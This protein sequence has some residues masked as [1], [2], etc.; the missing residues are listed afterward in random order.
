MRSTC[1]IRAGRFTLLLLSLLQVV[2]HAEAQD[3]RERYLTLLRLVVYGGASRD[4][5]KPP[6]IS[7]NHALVGF[8]NGGQLEMLL[9]LM[10]EVLRNGV[11]G[12]FM[13]AGTYRG[14]VAIFMAGFIAVSDPTRKVWALDSFRGMPGADY[15]GAKLSDQEHRDFEPGKLATPGGVRHAQ[16][17]FARL[18]LDHLANIVPGTLPSRK[19]VPYASP[20]PM[21]MSMSMSH[22]H[23]HVHV[24]VPCPCPCPCP[25]IHVCHVHARLPPGLRV[26]GWFNETMPM[27]PVKRLAILRVD[28]DIYSSILETLEHMYPKLS[29]GGY[30]LFDDYKFPY[31]KRAV[32]DFRARYGITSRMRWCNQDSEPPMHKCNAKDEFLYWRK[33]DSP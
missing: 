10:E 8:G 20:C 13:E 18:G 9:V 22:V 2:S 6:A 31:A 5:P 7:R 23:V 26:S 15:H 27:L 32:Q 19:D 3:S 24:H 30:V 16:R 11:R 28:S 12:D 21:S 17:N 33:G 29:T 25:C 4:M 1:G 14:G